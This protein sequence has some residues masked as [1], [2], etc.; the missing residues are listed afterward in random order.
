MVAK[1]GK[2]RSTDKEG[3]KALATLQTIDGI[4]AVIIGRSIGGKNVGRKRAVGA[5]KIQG[6][7]ASGFKGLLQTSRGIQ[8]IALILDAPELQATRAAVRAMVEQRFGQNS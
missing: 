7:T 4:K 3:R 2:H 6:E 5:F 1:R 8:E